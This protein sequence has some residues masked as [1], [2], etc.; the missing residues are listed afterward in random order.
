MFFL[1][2]QIH[3]APWEP[4]EHER[5]VTAK[6]LEELSS[7]TAKPVCP[8]PALCW[9]RE[10]SPV[11]LPESIAASKADTLTFPLSLNLDIGSGPGLRVPGGVVG[12]FRRNKS[13]LFPALACPD[14]IC[15]FGA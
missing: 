10:G 12:P 15:G 9:D 6:S 14:P 1:P 13:A 2:I 4:V 11:T 7:Q 3:F 5:M 8:H